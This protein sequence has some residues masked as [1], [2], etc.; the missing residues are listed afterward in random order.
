ML[1]LLLLLSPLL[2]KCSFSPGY[3]VSV[4]LLTN[5]FLLEMC[6]K[7]KTDDHEKKKVFFFD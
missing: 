3:M 6:S 2:C 7:A 4:D 5:T 1:L